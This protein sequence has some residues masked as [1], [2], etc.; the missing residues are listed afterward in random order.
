M[1]NEGKLRLEKRT[2]KAT[3]KPGWKIRLES[4][5]NAIRRKV[6]LFTTSSQNDERRR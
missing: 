4:S 5:I 2:K 1:E 6:V 3:Q